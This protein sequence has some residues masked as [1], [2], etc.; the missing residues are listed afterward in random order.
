[1]EK[2]PDK[3][4][5]ARQETGQEAKRAATREDDPKDKT[6]LSI[7]ARISM[8]ETITGRFAHLEFVSYKDHEAVNCTERCIRMGCEYDSLD[9]V[10]KTSVMGILIST[11]PA[12]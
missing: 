2:G 4:A 10:V 11:R 12:R 3:P 5:G 6:A 1:M 9:R 7:T 8:A